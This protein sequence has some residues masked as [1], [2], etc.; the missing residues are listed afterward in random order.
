MDEWI[1]SLAVAAGVGSFAA[2]ETMIVARK[3]IVID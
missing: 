2:G 3:I 1:Y